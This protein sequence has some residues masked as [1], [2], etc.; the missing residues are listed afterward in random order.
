MTHVI[1]LSPEIEAQLEKVAAEHGQ[2]PT[3]YLH[4]VLVNSLTHKDE[5]AQIAAGWASLDA[6]IDRCQLETGIADLAHQHDHYVHG[7]PK[8]EN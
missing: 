6:L 7:T 2:K 8:R 4:T 3:D 5:T 1:D